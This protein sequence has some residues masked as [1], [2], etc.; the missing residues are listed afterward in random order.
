MSPQGLESRGDRPNPGLRQQNRS[1]HRSQSRN[2]VISHT[3]EKIIIIIFFKRNIILLGE[4]GLAP[5]LYATFQNGLAYE[6]VPGCTLTDRTVRDPVIYELIAKRLAK[7]HKA[8]TSSHT[9]AVEMRPFLWDKMEQFLKL[10]PDVFSDGVKHKRYAC[11]KVRIT[12][13]CAK[14]RTY[15]CAY[16]ERNE[17]TILDGVSIIMTMESEIRIKINLI[18]ISDIQKPYC[19]NGSWKMR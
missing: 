7:L 17:R 4:I 10:V 18:I 8:A 2:Q 11:A 15:A 3:I 12:Y 13:A 5:K 1:S 6:F 19:R 14:V 9:A 16:T